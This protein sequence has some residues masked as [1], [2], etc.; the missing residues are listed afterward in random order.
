M[1]CGNGCDV[2]QHSIKSIKQTIKQSCLSLSNSGKTFEDIYN[3][4]F[5]REGVL[6]ESSGEG[7]FVSY[8]YKDFRDNVERISRALYSKVGSEKYIALYGNN[9]F[10]W[11]V[12]FW[13]ILKSGNNPLLINMLYTKEAMMSVI[14][15][16][17]CE[18]VFCT[19]VSS[20]LGQKDLL[21]ADLIKIDSDI[22]SPSFADSIALSTSGTTL[23]E[24]ICIY[25]GEVVVNQI[26]NAPHIV[27]RIP[28][29]M[30]SYDGKLKMLMVL[31]LYH[32]FGLE[33]SYLWFLIFGAI[34]VF[35]PSLAPSVLTSVVKRHKVTHIFSVPMLWQGIEKNLIS[36]IESRDD[37]T[38]SRFNSA[39]DTSIKLQKISPR[40]GELFARIALK[41]IR[42]SIFGDSVKFCISGGAYIGSNTLR[43]INGIGY[44]LYN[45]YGMTEIGIM[46]A[47][48]THKID[49]RL[50][51][52]IGSAF[53]SIETKISDDGHLLVRGSSVCRKIIVG[54]EER[55]VD[56]W[57]DTA[58][59]VSVNKFG[60]FDIIGR[61][62]DVVIGSGGENLNP[63]IAQRS[64]SISL[65]NAFVVLGNEKNDEL[66]LLVQISPSIFEKSFDLLK[67]EVKESISSLPSAYQIRR[68]YY[69]TDQLLESGE[70]KFNRKKIRQRIAS[71][72]ISLIDEDRENRIFTSSYSF[73]E[74][75][76]KK[77]YS[78]VL[79]R[80]CEEIN[81]NAHFI[82][83]LGGTSLEY[84]DVMYRIEERFGIKLDFS[85]RESLYT[86]SDFEMII[87]E[88]TD[89]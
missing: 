10:E 37:K 29:I 63:D 56:G 14:K 38:H 9:S 16:L 30:D 49:Q 1:K 28:R 58:D 75:E 40:L 25:S 83:D 54:G 26:L 80:S 2:N 24:K 4:M 17:G 70:I 13:A 66:V 42:N 8:T 89:K 45:G 60:G 65:A 23:V 76:L 35:P 22:S 72:D 69:T 87:K 78:Q 3:I 20:N 46:C 68:V 61:A 88:K 43:L 52:S 27:K 21:Y 31:P 47:N 85:K 18:T 39:L 7:G 74:S 55:S 6:C 34:F 81:L 71:Q 5:Y 44:P 50:T 12:A 62:S 48:F 51:E 59:I 36:E 33:A 57:F 79:R 86:L 64:I 53:D 32:I 67:E 19:H 77:I 73:V 15:T 41:D 84:Y 11:M 82:N